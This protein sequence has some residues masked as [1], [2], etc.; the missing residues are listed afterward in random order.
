VPTPA[1]PA[2]A[3]SGFALSHAINSLKFFAGILFFATISSGSTAS[4]E[5]GSKSF[6]RSYGSV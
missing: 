3:L 1:V 6:K 2:E 4:S 5:T